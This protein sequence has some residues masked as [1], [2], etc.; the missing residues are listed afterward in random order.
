[1]REAV[2]ADAAI[3]TRSD[4]IPRGELLLAGALA[5]VIRLIYLAGA[6]RSPLFTHPPLDAS[7]DPIYAGFLAGVNTLAAHNPLAPRLAQALLD[8]ASVFLIG[9]ATHAMWGR[10]AASLAADVAALYGPLV[11]FQ[12]EL[13]PATVD[14]FLVASLMCLT[15]RAARAGSRWGIPPALLALALVAHSAWSGGGAGPLRT[16]H[17][18]ALVWNRREAPC[19]LD[20]QF[21][22]A[23]NSPMFRL[24]WLLSFA[25]VGP[26][27]LVAAWIERRKAPLLAGFLLCATIVIA[28]FHVC[29]RTRLLLVAGAVPFVGFGLDR[30]VSVLKVAAAKPRARP[31]AALA[32]VA[33]AHGRTL[34]ALGFAVAFVTLPFPSLQRTQTGSGWVTLA[35]AHE[36][37]GDLVAARDAYASA[38]QSGMKTADLYSSWGRVERLSGLG[39]QA[40]QHLLAAIDLDPAH[41]AAH[42]TLGD[43]YFERGS[44]TQ[45]AQEYA[46]AAGL[47]PPRAAELYTHAGEAFEEDGKGERA[48]EMFERAL[49]A[50]PGYAAAEAGLMRM[51]GPGNPPAPDHPRE[52]S[53]VR[54][55]P[56]LPEK[57]IPSTGR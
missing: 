40:E 12:G 45:A 3:P 35:R 24:P 50:L 53:K 26:V 11:Y 22:A 54:M 31:G 8:S 29:D 6:A 10:R 44:Y 13:L 39:I 4:P 21:F 7:G 43:I 34:I 27:A 17:E 55:F 19:G 49:R 41:G 36:A 30:C 33:R 2:Q 57:V 38:E 48:T 16:L 47:N 20:Q 15:A 52:P 25:F 46:I 28:T 5:L 18:M 14:F 32:E 56:P 1:V 23:L 42:E 51:R 9:V 37:A